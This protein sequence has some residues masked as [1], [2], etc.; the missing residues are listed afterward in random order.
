[1]TLAKFRSSE[2]SKN[3]VRVVV[4]SDRCSYALQL[5]QAIGSLS[6]VQCAFYGPKKPPTGIA[7]RLVQFT[8]FK[9]DKPVWTTHFYIFQILIQALR[10]KPQ[11][12]HFDFT[13][14]IFGSSY[15]SCFPFPFLVFFLRL[16][17][18]KVVVT[19]HDVVT[20]DVLGD[21]FKGVTISKYTV[22]L[23][24]I[25]FYKFLSLGSIFIV[26]LK[27]Q[28]QMLAEMCYVNPEKVFVVPFGVED[29]PSIPEVAFDSWAKKFSDTKVVLFFGAIVP[30][31]G[32]EYL[33]DGFSIIAENCTD[34]TLV[35]AGPAD[36]KSLPYLNSLL[37][38]ADKQIGSPRF[39]YLG[40]LKEV[41]AHSLF[42][43]CRVV[44]LPYVYTYASPSILYWAV[45]HHK[46]VIASSIGTLSDEL[47]GYVS[48]L[49]VSPGDSKQIA[50]ALEKVLTDDSVALQA[51]RFMASKAASISWRT[52]AKTIHEIY[53][54]CLEPR[55]KD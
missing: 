49:L 35:M 13:V 22:W 36:S 12:I 3:P 55:S 6:N 1:M 15:L 28:R 52:V 40:Y 18:F 46:P 50:C 10:D 31:K 47:D 21:F 5:T 38:K 42:R 54:E 44:C 23:V 16:F 51:S 11:I 14:T 53:L 25:F 4:V 17:G 26:H 30:R 2:H 37:E 41:D 45:Q 7:K 8:G 39:V 9:N 29:V 48:E 20:K 27:L 19:V 24:S 43:L 34:S 33:I 32:I